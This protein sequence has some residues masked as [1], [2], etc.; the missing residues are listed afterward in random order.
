MI[1]KFES[2][3]RVDINIVPLLSKSTY[4][5]SF[6]DATRELVSNAYDADALTVKIIVD[7]NY[8]VVSI[9]DDGNGMTRN[10]FDRFITIAK[11]K[12]DVDYTKKYKRNRI[13]RFGIGFLAVFPFCEELRITT[14]TENSDDILTAIIPTKDFFNP[15][16]LILDEHLVGEIKISGTISQ[17]SDERLKHYTKI[18]LIKPT[19]SL[20][21][22]FAEHVSK[23]RSSI[24]NWEPLERYKW[25]LQEDLPIAF[26]NDSENEQFLNYQ[27]TIGITVQLNGKKIFRNPL[28]KDLLE[29]GESVAKDYK[30]K[31]LIS[32]A[33]RSV[34]PFESRGIKIR[35][36]NVGIGPRTEFFL[37][38]D[39][40]YSRLHW[41]SGEIHISG[42][43]KDNLNLNRDGFISNSA[44]TDLFDKFSDILRKQA[45]V[46]ENI[47]VAE[48]EL[49]NIVSNR[50]TAIVKPKIEII[51]QNINKLKTAG[52]QVIKD[53]QLSNKAIPFKINRSEKIVYVGEMD[54]ILF[55]NTTISGMEYK[56]KYYKGD[57]KS[58]P[59]KLLKDNVIEINLNY[60]LFRSKAYGNLFKKLHIILLVT[61]NK[62]NTSEDMYDHLMEILISEFK[63]YN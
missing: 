46:V 5:K 44:L 32:T 9:E 37:K 6:A 27:E 16:E 39:R 25:E 7:K 53:S 63:E 56:L 49:E 21:N 47:S 52:F 41:L 45:T 33:Y 18:E 35:V 20:I 23:R 26:E 2:E 38:R 62:Y 40:G 61:K 34:R 31:Y 43:I 42:N 59:C 4:Q 1:K 36:N 29:K 24:I 51:N 55:D 11:Q 48:N 3:I 58:Q 30:F 15:S 50:R 13:G 12:S 28:L 17:N 8:S 60:P 10:D 19:Y 22:Y 54:D 14:T 57:N